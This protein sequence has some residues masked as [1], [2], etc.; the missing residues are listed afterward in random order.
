M[1][2]IGRSVRDRRLSFMLRRYLAGE[3]SRLTPGPRDSE[4]HFAHAALDAAIVAGDG[5]VHVAVH[6]RLDDRERGAAVDSGRSRLLGRPICAAQGC[7]LGWGASS[8][9][10]R[11]VGV[12]R[13]CP[14][15]GDDAG[16]IVIAEYDEHCLP[17]AVLAD[18]TTTGHLHCARRSA[19]YCSTT[20]VCCGA[21]S[22]HC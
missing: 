5:A 11:A 8:Q 6:D 16:P 21:I 12:A 1:A 13:T 17:H 7:G 20:S 14:T 18:G 4:L 10:L 22:R 2:T 9:V 15:C 19:T 3:A